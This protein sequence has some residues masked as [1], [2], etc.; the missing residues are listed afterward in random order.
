MRAR[1]LILSETWKYLCAVVATQT[2]QES[3]QHK[4][5]SVSATPIQV[6]DFAD[7]AALILFGTLG[8]L[9]LQ[10]ND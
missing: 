6:S 8:D 1:P 10:L 7:V 4:D 5:F 3:V 2:T 9:P